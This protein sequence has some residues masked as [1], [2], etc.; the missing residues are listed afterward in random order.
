M[1]LLELVFQKC[2]SSQLAS[3][4]PVS[5]PGM[6]F[7]ECLSL[8]A[9]RTLQEGLQG[10]GASCFHLFSMGNFLLIYTLYINN[11]LSIMTI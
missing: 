5:F 11:Y 4:L 9:P 2:G 10:L 3:M 6:P 7:L 1:F 8:G